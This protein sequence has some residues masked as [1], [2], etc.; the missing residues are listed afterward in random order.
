MASGLSRRRVG[1]A[2]A[3]SD[4]S[5]SALSSTPANG[6]TS[7]VSGHA[8]TALEGGSKIA[9]DPRDLDT[10]GE[11]S[12]MPKLTLMEEVLLL[13]LNDRQ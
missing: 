2:S 1:N 11:S 13:G 4:S 8:G 5:P 12:K 10:E 6:A 9:F 3:T 7:P